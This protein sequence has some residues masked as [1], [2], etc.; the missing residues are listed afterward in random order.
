[1]TEK[2]MEQ[3]SQK[4][5]VTQINKVIIGERIIL[6]WI[7]IALIFLVLG[8]WVGMSLPTP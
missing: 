7:F 4:R 1:M 8:I 5:R 6:S 3:Y 2:R